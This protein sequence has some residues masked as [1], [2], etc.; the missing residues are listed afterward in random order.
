MNRTIYKIYII[1]V[2]GGVGMEPV[3]GQGK[4]KTEA[5]IMLRI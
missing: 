3:E 5:F 2:N 4:I 1:E